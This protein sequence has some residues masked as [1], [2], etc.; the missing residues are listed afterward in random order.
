MYGVSYINENLRRAQSVSEKISVAYQSILSRDPERQEKE[1]FE[2]LFASDAEAAQKDLIW[3]LVN[4]H[5]FK[6]NK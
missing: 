2:L 4:S 3:V 5:E 1:L 6:F